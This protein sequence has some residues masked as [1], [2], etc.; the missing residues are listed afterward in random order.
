MDIKIILSPKIIYWV[1]FLVSMTEKEIKTRYKQAFF[2]FLWI[3]LNPLLQMIVMGFIFQFFIHVQTNNYFLFLFSGLIPW[4]FFVNSLTKATPAFFYQRSMI[5]KAFFPR[6]SIVLSIILS[7]FFHY[8]ISILLLIVFVFI[9]NFFQ[10]SILLFNLQFFYKILILISSS[11]ILLFFTCFLSLLTSSLQVK[12][13]DVNFIVQAISSIWF[14]A[15]PIIYTMDLIPQNLHF[16][17]YINPIAPIIQFFHY[18]LLN[19][20]IENNWYYI[21]SLIVFLLV[22]ILGL[23]IYRKESKNFDDWL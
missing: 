6:E 1:D 18:S 19:L 15:T 20:P 21:I 13:R 17:F 12:Y 4:N 9:F 22:V 8:L 7:N 23:K 3:F 16:L 5:K 10:G 2:G 11:L 14:Y